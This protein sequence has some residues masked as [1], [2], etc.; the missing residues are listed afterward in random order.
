[1]PTAGSGGFAVMPA[2]RVSGR[3]NRGFTLIEL[4]VVIAII[5]ILAA[6]L[7]PVFARAR[8]RA[9]Q[10]TCVSNLKQIGQ[11]L[12]MYSND[13]EECLP[14]AKGLV[15]SSPA[16]PF[17]LHNVLAP[18]TKN[19]DIFR[20]PSDA[21]NKSFG[22]NVNTLWVAFGVSYAY[23]SAPPNTDVPREEWPD[24]WRGGRRLNEFKSAA[25]TGLS[26]DTSPWH[27]FSGKDVSNPNDI[28][29]AG[30]NVLFAD[31][32]VKLLLY[33]DQVNAMTRKPGL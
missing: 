30:Y 13:N 8:E 3:A 7:F 33:H 21:G 20:C 22:F 31:S 16:D 2:V 19:K 32:H 12:L 9:K 23:N 27:R 11:S 10:T 6:I 24:M 28:A 25:D 18:Y 17:A 14:R 4:L 26:T 5:A 15:S 29:Q 1:L